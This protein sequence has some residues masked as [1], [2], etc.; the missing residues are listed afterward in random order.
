MINRP[1]LSSLVSGQLP[2]FIQSDYPT[3]VA[4]I[5]AYYKYIEAT[6]ITDY[7]SLRDLDD[8][9]DTF[10][11][12][13]RKE[14][15]YLIPATTEL[16]ERF[17]LEHIRSLYESKGTEESFRILFR[18]VYNKEIEIRYPREHI[19]KSSDGEWVQDVS[20]VVSVS[21][22][23]IYDIVGQRV[24]IGTSSHTVPV[25][26]NRVRALGDLFEVFIDPTIY[27]NLSIGN[28]LYFNDI[29]ATI[30]ASISNVTVVRGGT[31]FYVGQLFNIPSVSGIDAIIKVSNV[32]TDGVLKNVSVINFGEGYE[33]PYYA[34]I[35]ST[36]SATVQTQFPLVSDQ[37]LGFIDSGFVSMDSYFEV[38]I[39]DPSY[40][41]MVISEFY[42]NYSMVDNNVVLEI[43]TA[44]LGINIGAIRKYPGYYKSDKGFL[45]NVFKLQD[46]FYY[47]IYSYVILCTEALSNY[48]NV[49][50][51]LVHPSGS[52]LFGEQILSNEIVLLSTLDILNRYLQVSAQEELFTSDTKSFS[53]TK[54]LLDSILL[55]E[56]KSFSL[57][58]QL[59]DS[60]VLSEVDTLY[61]NKYIDEPLALSDNET[62]SFNK[63]ILEDALSLNG[64]LYWPADYNTGYV[65]TEIAPIINYTGSTYNITLNN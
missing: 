47:Q 13:F 62:V 25:S 21:S 11:Q 1:N 52:K 37:T 51:S 12:Y 33:N 3:F 28:I 53:S 10:V 30:E 20:F 14:L 46:S 7:K 2:E 6:T 32:G 40:S 39:V 31:G 60:I 50:K 34:S 58:K 48:K 63:Y 36:S 64:N 38:Q 42:N 27:S 15:A 26:I 41:G 61:I 44:I 35:V 17:L 29:V 57:A 54:Q 45:S 22:G 16:D 8:T 65:T 55:S 18:M 5:E 56:V 19:F 24:S 59:L 23:D 49:V 43:N 4:F 9:L